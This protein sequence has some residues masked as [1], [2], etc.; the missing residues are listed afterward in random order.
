M[1]TRKDIRLVWPAPKR[2]RALAA[3]ALVAV[4]VGGAVLV[5]AR[6]TLTRVTLD[7]GDHVWRYHT[8]AETVGELL[9]EAQIVLE[10]EDY[11]TPVVS[12]RLSEGL[13]VTVRRAHTVALT[14]EGRGWL[15]RT[16]LIAPLDILI[17]Q[18]FT[19]GP[20][21]IILVDGRT[22]TRATLVTAEWAAPPRHLVLRRSVSITVIDDDRTL[23]LETAQIDVGRALDDAGLMLYL[24]DRVTPGLSAPVE[25]G[26]TIRIERSLPVTIIADG[27]RL[28]T[29]ACGPTVADA[30]ALIG[31]A[32]VGQ[33]YTIPP[34]ETPLE[35]GMVIRLVRVIEQAPQTEPGPL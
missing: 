21:D 4:T 5:T 1:E 34:L 3:G 14:A 16:Q 33:D 6:L 30:L 25:A 27:R 15:V 23:A 17:E 31:L 2:W 9:S 20:H 11:V 10:P 32:P 24:A 28:E 13:T 18:G 26:M 12:T 19:P 8:R 35:S 7:T 29:R 22:F